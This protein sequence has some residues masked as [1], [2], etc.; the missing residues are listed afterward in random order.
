MT[1][2]SSQP[3]RVVVVVV[4]PTGHTLTHL[5]VLGIFS[6]LFMNPGQDYLAEKVAYTSQAKRSYTLWGTGK[7]LGQE[8]QDSCMMPGT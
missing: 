4:V 3:P 7:P 2:A 1:T 6:N 8:I 5:S